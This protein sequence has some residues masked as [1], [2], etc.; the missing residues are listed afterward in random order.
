MSY[1]FPEAVEAVPVEEL[2]DVWTRPL[3]LHPRL[4]QGDRGDGSGS[5]SAGDSPKTEP[6]GRLQHANKETTLFR[7]LGKKHTQIIENTKT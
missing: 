4:D 7:T 2:S 5:G 1:N 3:V 6:V